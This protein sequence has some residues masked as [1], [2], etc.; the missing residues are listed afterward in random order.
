MPVYCCGSNAFGLVDPPD[1]LQLLE[2]ALVPDCASLEAASWSQLL[3]RNTDGTRRT[4]GLP[5]PND[6]PLEP[7]ARWLGQDDFVAALLEDGRI[8][9][10]S[11]GAVSTARFSL[12]EMNGRGELLGVPAD[13]PGVAH[14][15]PSLDAL[16]LQPSADSPP[17]RLV[18]PSPT[19]NG[20]STASPS[21]SASIRQRKESITA[22]S[23]GSAHFLLLTSSSQVHSYGDSRYGQAG[24]FPSSL[25]HASTSSSLP[26]ATIPLNHLS[27]F[28]GLYPVQLACGS[29]HSAV[30]TRE[31]SVYLFGSDKDGQ[32]GETSGGAD[33]EMVD[34]DTDEGDE[35]DEEV[36]QVACGGAHTVLLTESGK[37]WVAGANHHGE[38]GL[39]DTAPRPRFTR[40]SAIERLAAPGRV[41]IILCSRS[42]T[43]F[44]TAP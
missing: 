20:T 6:F 35:A 3:A 31:G 29:F 44:E 34:L 26:P 36:V 19:F 27:F 39:G 18:L 24:P 23:S 25:Y 2:P 32:C 4:C 13:D 8:K 28:D 22:L 41:R 11:D 30:R 33:P 21:A 1:Q 14:L 38:L 42:G 43:F 15:F 9:R 40:C 7:V 10:L 16:F 12:A 37:V 17:L 5:L